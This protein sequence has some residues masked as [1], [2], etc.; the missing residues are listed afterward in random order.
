MFIE[1]VHELQPTLN[2]REIVSDLDHPGFIVRDRQ[3]LILLVNALQ[4]G[5]QVCVAIWL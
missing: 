2:W 3:G 5:L 1:V 4:R